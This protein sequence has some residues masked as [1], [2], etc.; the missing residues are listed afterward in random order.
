MNFASRM[1][2]SW[3]PGKINVSPDVYRRVSG[4][5]RWKHRGPQPVKNLVCLRCTFYSE[6]RMRNRISLSGN[7]KRTGNG[8]VTGSGKADVGLSKVS[9]FQL[10]VQE[11]DR[12]FT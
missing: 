11:W 9:K 7:Q 3:A 8:Q 6:A 10:A 5:Y 4:H 2:S 12:R 1:E